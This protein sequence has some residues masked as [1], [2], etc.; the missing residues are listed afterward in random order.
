M[1]KE[2]LEQKYIVEKLSLLTVSKLAKCTTYIISKHLKQYGIPQRT[3]SEALTGRKLSEEHKN[4]VIQNFT[5]TREHQMLYGVSNEEKQ[6]LAD[7]KPDRTGI[8]HSQRTKDLMRA[9]AL[10]RKNSPEAIRKMSKTRKDNPLYSGE[11]H[12]LYGKTRNDMLGEKN[13]NW[14]GGGSK[15]RRGYRRVAKYLEWRTD[16]Y[17]R[18]DYTCQFCKARGGKLNVDH[19]KPFALIIKENNIKTIEQLYA[20]EEL[21][22]LDNGRTLCISCHRQTPTY[23]GGTKKLIKDRK[24]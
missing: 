21:W 24:G 1:D 14:T 5:A 22:A 10:G 3:I 12:P 17:E 19:V 6:R 15:L 2:W 9:K 4:K 23:G 20:C 8:K 11:N 18:D 16:C 13:P 7:I